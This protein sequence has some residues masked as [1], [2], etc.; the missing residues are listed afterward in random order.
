MFIAGLTGAFGKAT[1]RSDIFL[2]DFPA[3]PPYRKSKNNIFKKTI[4]LT[5]GF[6]GKR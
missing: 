3:C 4:N 2:Y 1:L 6:Y 5:G